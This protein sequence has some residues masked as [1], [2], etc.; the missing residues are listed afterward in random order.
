MKTKTHNKVYKDAEKLPKEIRLMAAEELENLE[1]TAS[2]D[3]LH[4][5]KK[6][7]GTTEPYY[8]LKFNNYRFLL[9]HD[10][11]TDTIEILTLKHRKDIYKKQNLPWLN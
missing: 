7:K 8:R 4:N 10:V 2:L 6:M 1:K 9:Y 3:E 11:E 5:V